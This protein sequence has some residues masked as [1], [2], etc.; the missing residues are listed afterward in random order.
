MKL[1]TKQ[2]KRIIKEELDAMRLN[3][4]TVR[5]HSMHVLKDGRD[6]TITIQGPGGHR[7]DLEISDLQSPLVNQHIYSLNQMLKQKGSPLRIDSITDMQQKSYSDSAGPLP[8][9]PVRDAWEKRGYSV[10]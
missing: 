3:E 1:T 6:A 10:H 9:G 7:A 4:E 8:Y 2:L 5:A